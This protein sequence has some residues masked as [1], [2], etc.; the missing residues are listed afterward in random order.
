MDVFDESQESTMTSVHSG[1]RYLG[2]AK[3]RTASRVYDIFINQDF[4]AVCGF[5]A[6][7]LLLTICLARVFP[8]ADIVSAIGQ[9]D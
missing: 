3:H 2:E 8:I 7:G 4:L 1:L 9:L 6:I 5:S